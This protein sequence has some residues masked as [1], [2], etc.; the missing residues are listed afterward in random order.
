MHIGYCLRIYIV[1]YKYL[2]GILRIL[3]DMW[4]S[5]K[6]HC[7]KLKIQSKVPLNVDE[8]RKSI[9]QL[10]TRKHFEDKEECEQ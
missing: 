9:V 5:W 2:E 4:L 1:G 3:L 8:Q 7:E 10:A 6:A